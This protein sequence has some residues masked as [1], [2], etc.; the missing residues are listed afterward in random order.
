[1]NILQ[2]QLITWGGVLLLLVAAL[3][4]AWPLLRRLRERRAMDKRIAAVGVEQLRHVLL[5]DGMGGLSYYEHLLLTPRGILVLM[6]NPRDGIIFGGEQMDSWA[7]VVGKRTIRFANPLYTLEGQL[8]TLRY[9]LPKI[10]LEG[11]VLFCGA[12]S[13]PKGRPPGVWSLEDLAAAGQEGMQQAVQPVIKAAWE[14]LQQRAR[15]LDPASEGYLLPVGHSPSY[16]RWSGIILLAATAAA[17]L[18]WR[19]V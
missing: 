13:F 5:E 3:V 17:W 7:Q 2:E 1:V 12:S 15:K 10:A 19:L 16:L 11:H 6:G 8:S 18:G 4:V 14:T 9:H